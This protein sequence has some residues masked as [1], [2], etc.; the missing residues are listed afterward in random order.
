MTADPLERFMRS[1]SPSIDLSDDRVQTMICGVLSQL[2]QPQ[3]GPWITLRRLLSP[4]L[5]RYVFQ[6]AMAALLGGLLGTAL[7]QRIEPVQHPPLVS[8]ISASL[9]SQPLGF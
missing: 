7:P 3:K 2:D 4:L 8:L 6:M 1:G 9:P 5:P